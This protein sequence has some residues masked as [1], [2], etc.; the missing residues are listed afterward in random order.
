MAH[1]RNLSRLQP[2]LA[3]FSAGLAIL[4]RQIQTM[5]VISAL[6]YV[7]IVAAF[8]FWMTATAPVA[9]D[10]VVM[11]SELNGAEVIELFP[12]KAADRLSA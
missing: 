1:P 12:T 6:V 3:G 8:Y 10:V 11:Q 2:N 7:G 9:E 5:I 4:V